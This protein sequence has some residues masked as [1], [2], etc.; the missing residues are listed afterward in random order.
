[1]AI[2]RNNAKASR[3]VAAANT[4]QAKRIELLE[5]QLSKVQAALEKQQTCES[6]LGAK[7]GTVTTVSARIKTLD[8]ALA[9]SKVD[10]NKYEVDRFVV[11]SWE[12]TIGAKGTGKGK[13]ETYTNYQVKVWLKKKSAGS[14][15]MERL[16]ERCESGKPLPAIRLPKKARLLKKRRIMMEPSIYDHH[17]G[18]LAWGKE[19]GHDYDLKIASQLYLRAINKFLDDVAHYEVER[20]IFPV[21]NDLFHINDDKAETPASHNRLDVDGRLHKVF[22]VAQ[23]AVLYAC[24]RMAA[25][26]DL[27]IIHIRGNHDPQLSYALCKYMEGRFNKSRHVKVDTSP[28]ER[29]YIRYGNSLNLLAHGDMKQAQQMPF[30]M[31]EEAKRDM[32]ETQCHEIHIGHTHKE[33]EFIIKNSEHKFVAT[34]RTIPS[35][36]AQDSWHHM[37]GFSKSGRAAECHFYDYDQGHEGYLKANINALI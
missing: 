30:N 16:L 34:V 12:V 37:K 5:K 26:A 13:P 23:E 28:N 1:M 10:L 22:E 15:G 35:L 3:E 32:I 8:E 21:G 4:K 25:V 27:D 29:K 11:N 36:T 9:Y 33:R 18:M 14:L 2:S 24:E 31:L 19:V 17:F 20:I 7:G 6:K